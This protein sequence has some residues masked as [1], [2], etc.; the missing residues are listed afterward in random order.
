MLGLPS[1]VAHTIAAFALAVGLA[2][3]FTVGLRRWLTGI[4]WVDVPRAD[5]WHRSPVPRPGGPAI[6]A[7]IAVS[8]TVFLPR[9][10]SHQFWGLVAGAA[11]VFAV[12]LVDDLVDLP[13][14]LKLTLLIIG[15]TVPLFW[16]L[17]FAVF[18]AP[19][20]VLL[21]ML[22]MLGMTNAVNWL[23]NMDGLASGVAAIAAGA[24]V[25]LALA[26]SDAAGSA[27]AASV[28]GACV[29]FLFFNFSPARIF[30]GDSGSG[31]LGFTLAAL[32]LAGRPRLV[33]HTFL[34]F[35]VPVMILSIPIFD[36]AIVTVT[37]FLGGRRLFQ[38]GRD[39]P[40]HRLVVLGLS[41]R[42]AVLYLYGLSLMSTAAAF[43]TSQLGLWTGLALAGLLACGFVALGVVV[44]QVRVYHDGEAPNGITRVALA[45][46][47]YKRRVFEI[48]LDL[49][50]ICVA[51]LSAYLLRFEGAIPAVFVQRMGF[52]LP[53]VIGAKVGCLYIAGV[54]RGDW[55][56]VG[57]LDLWSLA[58]A[59]AMGS[60]AA[61]A[62]LFV[63]TGLVGYSR[64]VF[65]IDWIVAFGLLASMRVSIRLLKEHFA[66]QRRGGR[67]VLIFGAGQGGVQVLEELRDNPAR[68]YQPVGFVDDDPVKQGRVIRGLPVLGDRHAIPSLVNAYRVEEVLFAVPSAAGLEAERVSLICSEAGVP[69]RVAR[70]SFTHLLEGQ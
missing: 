32:A 66:M 25:V 7:A 45:Q 10:L 43:V 63:W 64:A 58:K 44:T 65:V 16:G 62:G 36:T 12:G 6:V 57:L 17:S 27:A 46:M 68:T 4:G 24:M 51:Y 56:Y 29:G 2:V 35:I 60:A 23:D 53:L 48:L 40:S 69:C 47:I 39:H 26:Q 67:R 41:E 19:I 1:L 70:L 5:R 52:S 22:W 21:A 61:V 18:P 9:P 38:G 3:L 59:S 34:G 20:G 8:M 11:F 55:R 37:R 33:T 42:Q 50:L 13:N 54:Y 14:Q 30:M 15:A 49:I 28:A 31:F